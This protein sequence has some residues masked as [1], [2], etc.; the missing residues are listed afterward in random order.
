MKK[1][2]QK[3]KKLLTVLLI[4]LA[5]LLLSAVCIFAV[6]KIYL[7][8]IGRTD[9]IV[10]DRIAP[11]DETFETDEET[12]AETEQSTDPEAENIEWSFTEKIEADHLIN[13]LLIGQD[14]RENQ[15]RQR[16]DSM[17][18]LSI[19]PETEKAS[20][21]SFM[22]DLYVQI[23]GDYSDNRLN[24]PYVFGGFDLLDETLALNF[25]VSVDGN[26]EVDF[27]GFETIIDM[28]GGIDI[29]V[30]A[31]EAKA[32]QAHGIVSAVEGSNHMDGEAALWFSRIRHLDS[33][34]YRTDRQKKVLLAVYEKVKKL[35]V[36]DLLSLMYEIL[37]YLTTDLSDMEILSLA[38]RLIPMLTS[39]KIDTYTV[40]AKDAY[41]NARIRGMAV[42]VPDLER[43]RQYLEEEYLPLD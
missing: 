14:R 38:Y 40:P 26:F 13:I 3:K 29:E 21:I 35:P 28:I 20:M 30:T 24:A 33:D 39:L 41:Y 32:M 37:P 9:T 5:L 1:N 2:F 16:S 10:T 43:I 11:E 27:T 18:L 25:G 19:N 4:I 42:L 8:K 6:T 23:P 15:G 17:I 22:R 31:A 12:E 36:N 7:G 34:F